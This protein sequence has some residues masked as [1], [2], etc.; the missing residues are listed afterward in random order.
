MELKNNMPVAIPL[1]RVD[2]QFDLNEE[3]LTAGSFDQFQSFKGYG[4]QVVT[5][6][7]HIAFED[8]VA[9]ALAKNDDPS[10]HVDFYGELFVGGDFP[11]T[12]IPFRIAKTI[13]VPKIPE[14]RLAGTE[15]SP[16]QG[17]FIVN[18]RIKNANSFPIWIKAVKTKMELNQ[19]NY[20]LFQNGETPRLEAGETQTLSLKMT[21]P[22]GKGIGMLAS[23]L[24]SGKTDIEVSGNIRFG[25]PFGDIYLRV[26]EQASQN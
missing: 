8:I 21:N 2:Y 10:Y 22:L 3:R 17:E 26:N 13:P 11:F 12:S 5:F 16:L 20:E 18:F 6:P 14:V 25:T 19:R 4:R 15:G 1:D 23:V 9:H 24:I 7:F